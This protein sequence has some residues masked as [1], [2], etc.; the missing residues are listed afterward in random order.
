MLVKWNQVHWLALGLQYW[1][2]PWFFCFI[3]RFRDFSPDSMSFEQKGLI[4]WIPPF[5]CN[6]GN[7]Q[8]LLMIDCQQVTSSHLYRTRRHQ[9]NSHAPL[10]N[11]HAPLKIH[12]LVVCCWVLVTLEEVKS[13]KL[14]DEKLTSFHQYLR[15][16]H[17]RTIAFS[18]PSAITWA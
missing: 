1:H 18:K 15:Y 5:F 12:L 9:K 13:V 14:A 17:K 8:P 10:R 7:L 16:S 11:P 3:S 6:R 4:P 2:F